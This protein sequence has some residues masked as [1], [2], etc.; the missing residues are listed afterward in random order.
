MVVS[1]FTKEDAMK[2]ER[3]LF[4]HAV[5]AFDSLLLE[6][7][8]TPLTDLL[9]CTFAENVFFIYG[10]NKIEASVGS[11]F[12][13]GHY[14]NDALLLALSPRDIDGWSCAPIVTL[15]DN[16]RA[17]STR[18]VLSALYGMSGTP[19]A[20]DPHRLLTN[21]LCEIEGRVELLSLAARNRGQHELLEKLNDFEGEYFPRFRELMQEYN[22]IETLLPKTP[23]AR[24]RMKLR[25]SWWG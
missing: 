23:I 2:P 19:V 5:H 9:T 6:R 1:D 10:P 8:W 4:E 17:L 22:S 13:L 18:F 14:V 3:V 20:N 21:L 7:F 11:P 24:L 25:I 16:G 15:N 12:F